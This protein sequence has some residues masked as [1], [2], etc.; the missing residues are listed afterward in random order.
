VHQEEVGEQ[1]EKQWREKVT[2]LRGELSEQL[3]LLFQEVFTMEQ[4]ERD[5]VVEIN[6]YVERK[7][8]SQSWRV[9]CADILVG[10]V[11][12][13][14][15]QNRPS[16]FFRNCFE[17]I[18]QCKEQQQH[19]QFLSIDETT[20]A[21]SQCDPSQQRQFLMTDMSEF[22]RFFMG[23]CKSLL[24]SSDFLYD[25]IWKPI[26]E[27]IVKVDIDPI[28]PTTLNDVKPF[29]DMILQHVDVFEREMNSL[30]LDVT[31]SPIRDRIAG[32]F[33]ILEQSKSEYYLAKA[34][35]LLFYDKHN[36]TLASP[37]GKQGPFPFPTCQIHESV[38]ELHQL[39]ESI[40]Q[41]MKDNTTS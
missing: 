21:I 36:S 24:D 34:R 38:H 10:L 18:K 12:L 23:K 33:Q 31:N 39:I 27:L 7:S 28:I 2:L 5:M 4:S 17:S 35:D 16:K 3:E 11:R 30:G 41:E 37:L 13:E 22:A 20:F 8:T 6:D 14:L 26:S 19:L 29:Q 32:A 1:L 40:L 9:E 25:S 15:L